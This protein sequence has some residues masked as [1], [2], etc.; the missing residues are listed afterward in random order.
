MS[1]KPSLLYF[2]IT[3]RGEIIRLLYRYAGVE[4]EDRRITLSEFPAIKTNRKISFMLFQVFSNKL[5]V[6]VFLFKS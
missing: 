3:G 2:N 4:F 5:C 1:G 6:C